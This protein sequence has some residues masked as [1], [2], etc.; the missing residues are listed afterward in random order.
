MV[1]GEVRIRLNGERLRMRKA[2]LAGSVLAGFLVVV[3][4]MLAMS[5]RFG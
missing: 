3:M 4:C 1:M 5:M 2:F